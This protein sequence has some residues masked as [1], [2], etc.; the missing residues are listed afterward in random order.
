MSGLAKA[1]SMLFGNVK[2]VARMLVN[3]GDQTFVSERYLIISD[4]VRM[5]IIVDTKVDAVDPKQLGNLTKQQLNE[6]LDKAIKDEDYAKASQIN[7]AL[8]Q[9]GTE[10]DE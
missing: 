1:L 4:N 5:H 8:E 2:P 7:D 9:F 6:L 10:E 3:E